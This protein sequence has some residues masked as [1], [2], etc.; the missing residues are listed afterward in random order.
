[1]MV[2]ELGMDKVVS[3]IASVKANSP[4]LVTELGIDKDV[5]DVIAPNV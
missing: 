1:M 4:I 2:T 5:N 3:D